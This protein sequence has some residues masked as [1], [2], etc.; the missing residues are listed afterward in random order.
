M[1]K[2]VCDLWFSLDLGTPVSSAS[3]TDR[4][5]K[6]EIVLKM[7]LNTITETLRL[8]YYTV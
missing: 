3:K 5:D 6:T 7:A 8:I 1:I 2:F 4:H